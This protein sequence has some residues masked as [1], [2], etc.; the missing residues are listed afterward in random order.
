[1]ATT[2]ERPPTTEEL[3]EARERLRDE[4]DGPSLR[5]LS[6]DLGTGRGVSPD[7]A[8][9]KFSGD[10]LVGQDLKYE[11]RVTVTVTD[12]HG[13]VICEHAATI[14]YPAFRDHVD[15]HGTKMV[16]R[17]HTAALD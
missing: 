3:D 15:K 14:G 13:E 7:F 12:H 17:I 8:S 5:Q 6:F 10:A 9:L 4:H 2:T 16:E 1:M 11:Q